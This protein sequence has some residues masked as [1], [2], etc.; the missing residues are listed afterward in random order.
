[1]GVSDGRAVD[2]KPTSG[3]FDSYHTCQ[4]ELAQ[5]VEHLVEAQTAGVQV[6]DSE[7]M[8]ISIKAE[9]LSDKEQ[10][11]EH[12]LHPQPMAYS[13]KVEWQSYTLLTSG[14]YRVGPPMTVFGAEV[15]RVVW[16]HQATGSIPVTQTNLGDGSSG[17]LGS[18]IRCNRWVRFP[19]LPPRGISASG[20]TTGLQPVV[21][22]SILLFSTINS[23]PGALETGYARSKAGTNPQKSAVSFSQGSLAQ[24]AEQWA[25]NPKVARSLL[26]GPSKGF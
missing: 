25:F 12:Y 9:R 21:K 11:K 19:Y 6:L 8:G 16:D 4:A 14:Q 3:G 5:V 7:P 24:S 2:S 15:A 13:S 20:N 23:R 26:A 10:T 1:M 22:S 18:F 17:E